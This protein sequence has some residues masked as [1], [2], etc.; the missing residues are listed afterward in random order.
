MANALGTLATGLVI[1]RALDLVFTK[2]PILNSLTLDLSDESVAF[3]QTITSRI[4]GIPAVNNFGTGS[5]DRADTDVPVTISNFKEVHAGFTPQE[6][7]GTNRN[8]TEESA[9]PIAVAIA[10]HL[11]DAIAALWIAANFANSTIVASGWTYTNTLLVVRQ[12]LQTRGVPESNRFFAVSA[13]VYASLLGDSLVVAALN[14]PNN[15]G[16]I[17]TGKL[18]EA[19]G[20]GIAEYP[21]IPNTGNMVGF[22]ATKDSTVLAARVPKDPRELLPNAP[23]PGNLGVVTHARTG[24]S[25][26]VNEWVDPATLKANVRLLIMYGVAKGNGTNGQILKTA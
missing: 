5:V 1:Q 12:A 2:R 24:L 14:N 6:Y 16:A 25:V 21:G 13:A 18:P 26:M 19:A 17:S 20:F 15:G 9:E 22:A 7:S 11:V 8:L 10:N 3:N 23:F 4:Y